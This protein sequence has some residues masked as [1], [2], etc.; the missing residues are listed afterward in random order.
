MGEDCKSEPSK[1]PNFKAL[2]VAKVVH[3]SYVS[4]SSE[5]R[6]MRIRGANAGCK[7]NLRR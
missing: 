5:K 7:V 1:S 2:S 6:F 3:R 4:S